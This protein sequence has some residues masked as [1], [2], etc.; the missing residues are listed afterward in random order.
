MKKS[1]FPAALVMLS[2]IIFVFSSGCDKQKTVELTK[3]VYDTKYIQTPPDTILVID[4]I[5]HI[6][7]VGGK[8]VDT[9][10]VHDTVRTTVYVHDTVVTVHNI[11][12]TITVTHTDTVRQTSYAPNASLAIASM[13]VQTN[14]LVLDF[15]YQ[16]FGMSDGFVM[17]LS[18]PMMDI[19]QAATGTYD[20]YGVLEYWTTDWASYYPIEFYW[21]LTYKSGD[22]AIAANWTMTDPPAA[23]N[24]HQPGIK[25]QPRSATQQLQH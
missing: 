18:N 21:R 16:N 11:Y 2:A 5:N 10:R 15:A 1:L 24:N 3:Y 6:D 25:V 7:T 19:S 12:D 14:P 8:A 4:T 9:I 23:A 22:P 20:I 13:Q 17:Y